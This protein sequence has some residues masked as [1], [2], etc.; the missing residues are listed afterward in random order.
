MSFDPLAYNLFVKIIS[1]EN[2]LV[3]KTMESENLTTELYLNKFE[4]TPLH[5]AAYKGNT[6]IVRYLLNKGANANA[7]NTSGYTPL[8]LAQRSGHKEIMDLLGNAMKD[9]EIIALKA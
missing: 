2:Q 6:E 1:G 7:L 8:M 5:T 4:W 9:Q 3:M